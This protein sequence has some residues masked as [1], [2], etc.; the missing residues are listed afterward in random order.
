MTLDFCAIIGCMSTWVV[1]LN[2]G[3]GGGRRLAVKDCIDVAGMPTTVG[4]QVVAEMAEPAVTDAGVVTTAR[5][6]GARI[7]GKTA[8]TELCWS[9]NGVNSWAGP[10]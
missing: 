8:L 10:R 9:A 2:S 1:R 3:G 4:C 7:V 6:A 5:A